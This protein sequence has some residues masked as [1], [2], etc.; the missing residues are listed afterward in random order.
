MDK[1]IEVK[2]ISKSY[3]GL[4]ALDDISFDLTKGK[5]QGLLGPS[6]SGKSTLIKILAGLVKAD[7]GSFRIFANT[8]NPETKSKI[9]YKADDMIIDE[10]LRIVDL[11]DLNSSFY[12]NF[13][14]EEV[15]KILDYLNLDTKKGFRG[16][17]KGER[18]KLNISLALGKDA[19]IYLLDEVFDGLDPISTS[20]VMDLLIDKIDGEKTF[21]IVS[22]QLE[23]VESLLDDVIFL[24]KGRIHYRDTALG[25]NRTQ[26]ADISEFYDNIYLD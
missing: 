18:Q 23:L 24:D 7:Q 12:P 26:K 16:L 21:V 6:G 15:E 13:S 5:V 11:I 4:L 17:S 2:N 3:N 19:D 20:K 8:L 9:A 14:I 10:K 22:Q 1:V 25:I